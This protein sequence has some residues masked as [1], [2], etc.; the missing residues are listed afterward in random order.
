M[1][2]TGVSQCP[3]CQAVVNV[4]WT[5]CPACHCELQERT[6]SSIPPAKVQAASLTPER[7]AFDLNA[8]LPPEGQ[9]PPKEGSIL[10]GSK[11][12]IRSPL[13]GELQAVVIE[14]R[15]ACIWVWHP[16]RECECA[17]PRHWITE[18]SEDK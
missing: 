8:N 4:K 17:I 9:I 5:T 2:M 11:V 7:L 13:F 6:S 12:A 10:P 16:I 1:P 15:G 3:S 14:D 18:L